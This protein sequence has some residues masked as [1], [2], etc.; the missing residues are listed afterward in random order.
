MLG[1]QIQIR[2]NL[3]A[4]PSYRVTAN[5]LHMTTFR[6]ASNDRR[7]DR[8][9]NEWTSTDPVYLSVACWRQ[10]ADN[11]AK[12]VRKGDT[13][14]VHGRLTMREYD[15]THGG[16]RRQSYEIEAHSVGP[17]LARYRADLT[18]PA[19]DIEPQPLAD[20]D[21]PTQPASGWD[22]PESVSAA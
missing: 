16:P 7:F 12:T 11:V 9:R 14:I 22:E 15:D 17:D 6:I 20:A 3:V 2:G 5:G 8:E 1:P 18:R 21:L 13:V 10:L 19:R 4:N